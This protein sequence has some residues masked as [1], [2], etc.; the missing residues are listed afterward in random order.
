MARIGFDNELKRPSGIP[1]ETGLLW[2]GYLN[3]LHG[4]TTV[5]HH[6]PYAWRVFERGFPI[7]VLRR[8]LYSH[9]YQTGNWMRVR[10]TLAKAMNAPYLLHAG[11]GTDERS[12]YEFHQ[13]SEQGLLSEHTVLIHAV[14]AKNQEMNMLSSAGSSVVW[15]PKSNLR[16]LGTTAP[17][18][19]LLKNGISVALGTDSRLT[20]SGGLLH[21]LKTAHETN[22]VSDEE[23]VKMV[24]THPAR[25][26][27]TGRGDLTP[28]TVADVIAIPVQTGDPHRDL[29]LCTPDDLGLVLVKGEPQTGSIHF[30]DLFQDREETHGI[31]KFEK[32]ERWVPRTL[33][34]TREK[35][36]K[37]L[38]FAPVP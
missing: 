24:T 21:E 23:L 12:R 30:S 17:V 7:R 36:A 15:C 9:T 28:G 34:E 6:D 22:L 19:N 2:G 37:H 11:E 1:W 33:I 26:L 5:Q 10:H 20:G 14:G 25:I 29:V 16:I 27:R 18:D 3:L 35:V 31:T 13:L 38:S 4:V 32:S 8:Y